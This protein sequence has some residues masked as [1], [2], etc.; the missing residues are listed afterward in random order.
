MRFL[1]FSKNTITL[2]LALLLAFYGCSRQEGKVGQPKAT[3]EAENAQAAPNMQNQTQHKP[4]TVVV[5]LDKTGS[6][7]IA[8]A[9][10]EQA[11]R[12]VVASAGPGDTW[13]FRWIERDSYSVKAAI[14]TLRLPFLPQK[15][16]NP[17]DR[18]SRAAWQM[19]MASINNLK[20]QAAQRLIALQPEPGS[21]TQMT[22]IWGFL[23]KASE[24]IANGPDGREKAIV[25]ASDLKD[26]MELRVPLNL[27][28]V[29]VVVLAFQSGRQDEAQ[30]NRE[31]W[32]NAFKDSG[33]SFVRFLDPSES[34]EDALS[35]GGTSL[36]QR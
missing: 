15:S 8:A 13:F 14:F 9:G 17:F 35:F 20:Q 2:A 28:G 11:A 26:N 27:K 36:S 16:E 4:Q 7:D 33:A 29:Y 24:L 19:K 6:Y 31:F 25:M 10:R 3:V 22:D 1:E 30:R 21:S 32:A 5:G 12:L 18:R 34:P 23:A